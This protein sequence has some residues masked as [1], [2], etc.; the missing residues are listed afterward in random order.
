M[1]NAIQKEKD[2][3]AIRHI[4]A[5]L[6]EQREAALLRIQQLEAVEGLDNEAQQRQIDNLERKVD[7]ALEAAE[8]K[9][10]LDLKSLSDKI[11][12]MVYALRNGK[13]PEKVSRIII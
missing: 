3:D 10:P 5:R 6:Y 12:A 9:A 4:C 11:L 2:V 13:R 8:E 1:L 7:L